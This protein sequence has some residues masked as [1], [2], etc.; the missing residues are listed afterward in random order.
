MNLKKL[1]KNDFQL[2][3]YINVLKGDSVRPNISID[4]RLNNG[5]EIYVLEND[6][7]ILSAICIA[8][9]YEIPREIT[10]LDMFMYRDI[11]DFKIAV[12]Y[13]VWSF[14]KG[15]GREIIIRLK[16]EIKNNVN[17]L[18]TLSPKT[19]MAV[20]FHIKNGAKLIANNENS[21]NFEY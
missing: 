13:T 16:E 5:R 3:K 19:D 10:D 9:T 8:Y 21:Y 4:F 2:E 6:N 17:K 7:Q 15:S 18:I 11:H 12:A 20:K 1:T 14:S